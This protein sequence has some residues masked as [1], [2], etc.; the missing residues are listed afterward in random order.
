MIL[1]SFG[2][3]S[4]A[5]SAEGTNIHHVGWMRIDEEL[6]CFFGQESGPRLAR[7]EIGYLRYV[8]YILIFWTAAKSPLDCCC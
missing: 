5:F 3:N 6:D 2:G 1:W 7:G 4:T 8:D